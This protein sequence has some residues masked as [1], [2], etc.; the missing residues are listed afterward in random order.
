[1]HGTDRSIKDFVYIVHQ[2]VVMNF[3]FEGTAINQ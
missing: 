2:H 1:M 3:T